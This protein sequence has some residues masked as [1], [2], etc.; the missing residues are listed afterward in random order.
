MKGATAREAGKGIDATLYRYCSTSKHVMLLLSLLSSNRRADP[1]DAK[2]ILHSPGLIILWDL[3][4]LF[5]EEEEPDEN[6][7]DQG[8]KPKS[9][10][11]RFRNEWASRLVQNNCD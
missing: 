8:K 10:G 2:S 9:E 4:R 6:L 3:A 7:P 11:M 5:M 1:D